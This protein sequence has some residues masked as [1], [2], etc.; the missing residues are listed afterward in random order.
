MDRI[1]DIATD[2]RHLSVDRGFLVVSE[3]REEVGRVALD[4]IAGVIVHAHGVSYSNNLLVRLANQGSL[5]VVCAQNHSPVSCLWPISGHHLQ[6]AR[7][8]AQW[9]AG[10]PLQKRLWQQVVKNK[11][12]IQ[13]AVIAAN[14]HE[15]TAFDHLARRVRSGDPDNIE[16]QAARRYWPMLMGREFTR[17]RM[18][19][20][21]NALLNYGYTVLRALI[22]RAIVASGLHPTIGIFHHNQQN[23][24][25]LA[26]DLMEP[27]RPFVDHAVKRLVRNGVEDVTP[28]AKASLAAITGFDVKI[29]ET[30]SPVSVAANRVAQS[31]SESF[32]QSDVRLE[33]PAIPVAT[34]L[35][36][37]GR[38]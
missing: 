4:E 36:P 35:S 9:N 10:R 18:S 38:L 33:L 26:D 5:L 20:G 19:S 22:G 12:S 13:G 30:Y 3:D 34:T 1:V 16:A 37:L 8:R 25:A 23:A 17:D 11:I 15:A 6:N 29:G 32:L 28:E 7:I 14:G 21:T 27:F 24:L 2:G 31:L